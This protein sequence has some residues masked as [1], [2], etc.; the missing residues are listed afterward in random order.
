MAT[1]MKPGSS[2]SGRNSP[3]LPQAFESEA[4]LNVLER[5]GVLRRA[6]VLEE[7]KQLRQAAAKAQGTRQGS[8]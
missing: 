4:L 2:P 8:S 6:E 1:L 7:I 3:S 5:R